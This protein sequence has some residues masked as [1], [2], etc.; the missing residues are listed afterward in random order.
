MPLSSTSAAAGNTLAVKHGVHSETI[1][2]AQ[3][4]AAVAAISDALSETVPFLEPADLLLIERAARLVV[5]LRNM[6][7]H[8][9]RLGG[10]LIDKQGRPRRSWQLYTNLHH[11]LRETL[12][13]LG[14]G[15][16]VRAAMATG[17]AA[18]RSARA[19]EEAQTRLRARYAPVDA[20]SGTPGTDTKSPRALKELEA[21]E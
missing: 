7:A 8:Y 17:I 9:D 15:P 4:P 6:E 21:H 10:S 13:Q 2:T 19:T 20:T 3:M 16:A 5:Q 18:A 12:K 14:V 1:V 11:Q